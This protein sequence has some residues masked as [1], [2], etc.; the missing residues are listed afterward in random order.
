MLYDL[1]IAESL[2]KEPAVVLG[3]D[4]VERGQ[5]VESRGIEMLVAMKGPPRVMR[6]KSEN[7]T[8]HESRIGSA[9]VDEGM[10]RIIVH[11]APHVG[12]P[13]D[14]VEDTSEGSVDPLAR[15]IGS[16]V[17]VMGYVERHV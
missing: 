13:A 3:Q 15:R 1:P 12:A 16:M 8:G 5:A 10:V 17:G 11:Q 7:V 9:N 6:R 2:L 14:Q 4:P